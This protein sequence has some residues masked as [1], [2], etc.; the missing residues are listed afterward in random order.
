[1]SKAKQTSAVPGVYYREDGQPRW[2]VKVRWTD[3]KG[4]RHHLR[5]VRYPVNPKAQTGD[6]DHITRARLDAE[7]YA[8]RERQHIKTYGKPHA[9]RADAWTLRALL[10]R[11]LED[12]DA[13]QIRHKAIR[14]ERSAIRTMLGLGKG[15]NAKGFPHLTDKWVGDLEY[16]DFVGTQPHSLQQKLKDREGNPAGAGA[17]KRL[18]TVVRGVFVRAQNDW[19]IELVNPLQSIKGLPVSDERE[20]VITD[21]EW[22]KITKELK[23]HE[24]GTQ[25][26][27]VFARFTAARRSEVVKLD[28]PDIDFSR[29]TA[30][31]R[32]TKSR[33]GKVVERVIPLPAAAL[34]I[35]VRR[36]QPQGSKRTKSAEQLAGIER[37]GPVFTSDQ[38]ERLR[39]DT[40]TQ[41]WSRACDRAGVKGARF[42]DL[43]HTRITELGRFLSAA[44]A[45]RVSGHTDLATFFRYFNPDPAETGRKIDAMEQGQRGDANAIRAAAKALAALPPDDFAAAI[46]AAIEMRGRS[47]A[48]R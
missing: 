45:A 26:A 44:E 40:I 22:E 9:A 12:L 39:A 16:T 34:S 42:H 38:G 35:L 11:Y 36:A 4:N 29:K 25:D 27:I 48:G 6:V 32:E 33:A 46:A 43:R 18:L 31:L 8:T 28:W 5:T 20:R 24:Q 37:E 2:E 17:L 14:T 15:Q 10:Q 30:R 21:T 19:Q 47:V 41:A 1:M 23:Q 3:K 13:G 7:A